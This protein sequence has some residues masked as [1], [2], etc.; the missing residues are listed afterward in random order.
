MT[1]PDNGAD[2]VD[3]TP[4]KAARREQDISSPVPGFALYGQ[5]YTCRPVLR[6]A[7]ILDLD[8]RS[9][10]QGR[11]VGL[12]G[13]LGDTL[14]DDSWNRFQVAFRNPEL[15]IDLDVLDECVSQ[16]IRQFTARPTREPSSSQ[17]SPSG[18]GRSGKRGSAKKPAARSA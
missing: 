15:D 5:V 11:T 9:R 7:V 1:A 14:D 10:E 18:P 3:L 2:Y 4:Y 17:A 8:V 12:F 6:A 13:F 16:V